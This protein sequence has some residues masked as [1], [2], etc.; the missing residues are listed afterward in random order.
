MIKI[1]KEFKKKVKNKETPRKVMWILA[2]TKLYITKK[3][4]N[5]RMGKGRGKPLRRV[6]KVRRNH[7]IVQFS[8]YY[9]PKL[10][11]VMRKYNKKC[12]GLDVFMRRLHLISTFSAKRCGVFEGSRL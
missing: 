3:S 2:P 5:A 11:M 8:R 9:T 7:I 12:Y 10:F 1:K 6:F 4:R